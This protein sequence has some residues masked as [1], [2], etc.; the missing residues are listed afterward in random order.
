[1]SKDR[2]IAEAIRWWKRLRPIVMTEA[3]HLDNPTINASIYDDL[4][5]QYVADVVSGRAVARMARR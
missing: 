5:A 3:E 2:V 4:L 1:M